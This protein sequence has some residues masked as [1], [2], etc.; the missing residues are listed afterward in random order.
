MIYADLFKP[1]EQE[2]LLE[3]QKT[4]G[5]S[6][7][8]LD[9]YIACIKLLSNCTWNYRNSY[10]YGYGFIQ[11]AKTTCGVPRRKLKEFKPR[12]DITVRRNYLGVICKLTGA[13]QLLFLRKIFYKGPNN[14][15]P[16]T[17]EGVIACVLGFDFHN[18]PST[19][20]N[21]QLQYLPQ[22]QYKSRYLPME[23]VLKDINQIIENGK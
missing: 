23:T 20:Y 16:Q 8:L 18:I 1:E 15:V 4:F 2:A 21:S 6:D 10:G 9:T 14:A 3:V 12:S 17:Q 7:L 22:Y 11:L 5:W 19:L 13:E